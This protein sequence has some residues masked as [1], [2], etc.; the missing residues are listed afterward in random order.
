MFAESEFG[1]SFDI[2][3]ELLLFGLMCLVML[4][5]LSWNLS[6]ALA[7]KVNSLSVLVISVAYLIAAHL[8]MLASNVMVS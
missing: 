4:A 1:S 5:P 3:Q 7:V 2:I 6:A 8:C